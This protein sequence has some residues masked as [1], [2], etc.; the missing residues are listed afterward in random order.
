MMAENGA[1]TPQ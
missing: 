1:S